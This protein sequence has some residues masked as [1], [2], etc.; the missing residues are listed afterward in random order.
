M[1]FANFKIAEK[2][3]AFSIKFGGILSI[4]FLLFFI[5]GNIIGNSKIE[6]IGGTGILFSACLIISGFVVIVSLNI[7]NLLFKK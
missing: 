7:Y 3:H 2:Y 5:L 6:Y 1:K 4:I